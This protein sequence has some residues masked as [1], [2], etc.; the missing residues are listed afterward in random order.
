MLGSYAAIQAV[1]KG[2]EICATYHSHPVELPGVRMMALDLAEL[3]DVSKAVRQIQPKVIVHTAAL[4]KPDICARSPRE[5]ERANIVATCNLVR[6]AE[7]VG[8]RFVYVST[9]LV[10]R[11]GDHAYKP[12]D[13]PL[14]PNY[15]GMTKLAGESAVA[16][17][18]VPWAIARTSVIYGPRKFAHLNSFSDKVIESLRAGKTMAAFTD[19]TRCPIPAWNLADACLE[20]AE[21]EL[22]GIFHAVC[23][24]P[25]TRY[26]FAVKVANVF[27][28]D[29]RLTVPTSMDDVPALAFRPPILILDTTSTAEALNTKLLGF[30]EGIMGLKERMP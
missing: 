3:R 9:D 10:F 26:E 29:E 7:E 20:I 18:A 8:A 24:E 27:G 30:E 17:S 1:E 4:S 2:W 19:Q 21:R 12:D 15:Y 22:T 5:A 28:L 11:G 16:E 25:S 23:P 13:Q 14:P 6:A